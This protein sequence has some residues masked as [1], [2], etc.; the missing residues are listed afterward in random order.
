MYVGFEASIL[1]T[2]DRMKEFMLL[3]LFITYILHENYKAYNLFLIHCPVIYIIATSNLFIKSPTKAD[4]I[5]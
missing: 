1:D 5:D 3:F 2:E 4:G